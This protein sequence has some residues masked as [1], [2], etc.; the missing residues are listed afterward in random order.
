MSAL[1]VDLLVPSFAPVGELEQ[2]AAEAVSAAETALDDHRYEEAAAGLAGMQISPRAFPELA[3][4]AFLAESWA[5]MYLGQILEAEALLERARVVADGPRFTD[6]DRA[7]VLY[8]LGC[9]RL[10]RFSVT[11]AVSLLTLALELADRSNL[12]CDRLRA[13]ILEWRARCYQVQ[14]EW[15]A[16]RADVERA[17]ELAEALGDETTMAHVLFQASIVSE[18]IGQWVVARC[19][20]EQAKD[21]FERC[22]NRLHLGR[23][24]NNLGGLS[25]LLDEPEKAK[26]YLRDAYGVALEVGSIA[27]AAQ[28]ISSLAQV[29]LRTGELEHAERQSRRALELLAGRVDFLDEIGNAQLVLGRSLAEQLRDEEAAVWFRAAEETF[30]QLGSV[31]HR[32]AVWMAE[33]ELD[34]K[35]DRLAD[36]VAQYRRAAEALQDFHF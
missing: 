1:P 36:A 15:E 19:Y 12:P 18:R 13:R 14:R 22:G 20:A 21:A 9:C 33:G 28:A 11:N 31:S 2:F 29:H 17:L 24:L 26:S 32:A 3:V 10:Q 35:R 30:E 7:E 8:R 5:R 6:A 16:A 4:R 34:A 25:F 23:V 27:D